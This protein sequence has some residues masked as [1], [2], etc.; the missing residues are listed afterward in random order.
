M[1]RG[2]LDR[3]FGRT[4]DSN[5]PGGVPPRVPVPT[6]PEA[7]RA[8]LEPVLDKH[9][10]AALATLRRVGEVLPEK[11]RRIDIGIH[12]AQDGEGSFTV[13]VHL[14]GPDLT[15]LNKAIQPHRRLIE[16]RH[17]D[18]R[19][20]GLPVFGWPDE[21]GRDWEVN[22]V[23]AQTVAQWVEAVWRK[24][25]PL[26]RPGILFAEE[27]WGEIDRELPGGPA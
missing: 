23:I 10:A 6:T 13:M 25:S 17:V 5:Q 26:P 11:A 7:Y 18:I 14:D 19:A 8:L 1:I 27:G 20:A 24:A 21:D 2:W 15:V 9:E 3:L 4:P 22:D 12:P 16:I